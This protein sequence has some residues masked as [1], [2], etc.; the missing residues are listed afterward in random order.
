MISMFRRA[1]AAFGLLALIS[2]IAAAPANAAT[3]TG[4]GTSGGNATL[5]S[6]DYGDIIQASLLGESNSDTIDPANGTPTATEALAPLTVHSVAV[7]ALDLATVPTIQ[8][9]STGATDQKTTALLDLSTLGVPGLTGAVDPAT[10]TSLVDTNGARSALSSTLADLDAL[11]L[12]NVHS[13]VASLGGLAA[14]GSSTAN[15]SLTADAI[16][17]LDLQGLLNLLGLDVTNLSFDQLL[18]LVDSL[19]LVPALNDAVP[20]LNAASIQDVVTY[21]NQVI[22]SIISNNTKLVQLQ[23]IA[24]C[25]GLEPVVVLLG[26]NCGQLGTT[27]SSVTTALN[28]AVAQVTALVQGVLDVVA[29]T[30]LVAI[31]G[32]TVGAVATAKDTVANSSA[33]VTGA[34]N[35][36]RVGGLDLG[37]VDANATLDQVEA[38][39]TNVVTT[40]N[41]ALAS[42]DPS[43]ANLISLDLLHR[44]TAVSTSGDYVNAVAGITAA[45]LTITPPDLCDLISHLAGHEVAV[46]G[47]VTLPAT[48]VTE[49]LGDV[50]S[51]VP[52]CLALDSVQQQR[53]APQAVGGFPGLTGPVTFKAASVNSAATFK[54]VAAPATPTTP[55]SPSLPRT[56]MNETLLLIVGGLMAAAALGIRRASAAPDQLPSRTRIG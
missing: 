35:D 5:L 55:T 50:G 17:V 42:I 1:F 4:V 53:L 52:P 38:L 47:G 54:A 23:A 15:R 32:V 43:L 10:L 11:G 39:A 21:A 2:V 7:P 24:V 29:G 40:L 12:I 45:T 27:I 51:L 48:P 19:G 25:T 3:P 22:A 36:I 13:V 16:T 31:D 44:A 28:A 26:I 9:T 33:L 18:G 37:G 30:P 41:G 8:T 46:P 14:P 6:V 34:I 56:G 49:L 20:G